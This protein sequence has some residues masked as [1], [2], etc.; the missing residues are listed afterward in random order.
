MG[1]EYRP[2]NVYI[3][4]EYLRRT[5]KYAKSYMTHMM[6]MPYPMIISVE[7]QNINNRCS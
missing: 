4:C 1:Y 6:S 5:S 7:T 3:G 2:D